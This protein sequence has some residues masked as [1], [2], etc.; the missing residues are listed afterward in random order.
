MIADGSIDFSA[1]SA[2]NFSGSAFFLPASASSVF[3][4]TILAVSVHL[5][6]TNLTS[7]DIL[8]ASYFFILISFTEAST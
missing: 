8:S 4:L 5:S 1:F 7:A 6:T 3:F 2:A